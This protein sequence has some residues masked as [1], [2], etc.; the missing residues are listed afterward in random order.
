MLQAEETMCAK[1][2]RYNQG[3]IAGAPGSS[4]F[5]T[6]ASRALIQV[7]LPLSGAGC[8]GSR[9]ASWLSRIAVHPRAWGGSPRG[10]RRGLPLLPQAQ[11]G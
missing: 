7:V 10:Y 9:E 4:L 6:V 1:T 2:Q 5:S 8:E 3:A 11:V